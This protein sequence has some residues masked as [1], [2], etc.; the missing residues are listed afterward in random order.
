MLAG[1]CYSAVYD[2][3]KGTVLD[4]KYAELGKKANIGGEDDLKKILGG[5]KFPYAGGSGC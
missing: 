2:V 1:L 4:T 5:C 3:V